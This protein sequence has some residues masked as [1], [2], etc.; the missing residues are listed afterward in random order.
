MGRSQPLGN[1]AE[2]GR[3]RHVLFELIASIRL[4]LSSP[5]QAIAPGFLWLGDDGQSIFSVQVQ[6]FDL[7]LPD[8]GYRVG[9]R[10]A[11]IMA[12]AAV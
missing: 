2:P 8:G 5:G 4:A 9:S 11:A 6:A 12:V 3:V 1:P 10:T 7:T